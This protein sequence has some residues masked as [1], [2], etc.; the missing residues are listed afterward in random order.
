MK[1]E[2]YTITDYADFY[3]F[4]HRKFESRRGHKITRII[5]H[6]MAGNLTMAQFTSI[7]KSKR[8]MSPT[9]SVHTDG[10]VVAWTPEEMRQWTTGSFEAD[11]CALTLEIA[12]DGGVATGW[13]ISDKAY[14]TAVK[15]MADWCKRYGIEPKY[16]VRG[17]G[18]CMHK[19][20]APTACPADYMTKKII[21][22]Q[23]ERDIRRAMNPRDKEKLKKYVNELYKNVLK[24][25]ADTNGLN[26]WVE[27]LYNGGSNA[28][29]IVRAFF[30]S[31][32]YIKK[33]TNDE[34]FVK[35]LYL[36]YL[37]RNA[38]SVGLKYWLNQLKSG[39][40][41]NSIMQGFENSIEF[42]KRKKKYTL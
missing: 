32:E 30:N 5:P 16:S 31:S 2:G 12:N 15:I 37:G 6:H 3:D 13:H 35:D 20:F 24:R 27:E 29:L 11:C 18:I 34:Q 40:S 25:K 17:S 7:M 26:Y 9:V 38:D 1:R 22:G 33:K 4:S 36:G 19:D 28:K 10:T 23:L 42:D 14:E 21:S 39:S 8:Q 41:R